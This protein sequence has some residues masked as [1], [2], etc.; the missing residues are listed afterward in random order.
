MSSKLAT[1]TTRNDAHRM[2]QPRHQLATLIDQARDANGWSDTDIVKRATAAGH[3]LGKSNLSRIR[4]TEVVSITASTIRALAAGLGV[5]EAEVARAALASMGIEMPDLS[6]LDLETVV[7]VEPNLSVRDKQMLLDMLR[8]MLS[9]GAQI[10][11]H[12]FSTARMMTNREGE[13][14]GTYLPTA[15]NE[16]PRTGHP[17]MP[18]PVKTKNEQPPDVLNEDAPAPTTGDQ[19]TFDPGRMLAAMTEPDS[20][21][22]PEDEHPADVPNDD[23]EGR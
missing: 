19:P 21:R 6:G 1:T 11:H 7:K 12:S 2:E 18:L 4:N 20:D 15:A 3:K 9:P 16:V 22:E 10:T 13:K 17:W 8:I 5:P 23:F 14:Y